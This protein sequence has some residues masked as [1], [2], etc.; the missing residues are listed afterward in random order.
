VNLVSERAPCGSRLASTLERRH[1]VVSFSCRSEAPHSDAADSCASAPPDPNVEVELR[2]A[3]ECYGRLRPGAAIVGEL[4]LGEVVAPT[5]EHNCSASSTQIRSGGA[6][7]R[8]RPDGLQA[9][10]ALLASD[11]SVR[12]RRCA[13]KPADVRVRVDAYRFGASGEN[14]LGP[15]GHGFEAVLDASV[16]IDAGQRR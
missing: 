6:E 12:R 8:G 2:R 11:T 1:N 10:A 15:R 7:S 14:P 16:S 3:P 5:F 13:E 4:P 9:N